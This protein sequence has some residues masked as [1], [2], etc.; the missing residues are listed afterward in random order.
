M[1]DQV[2]GFS[3]DTVIGYTK[4][5]EENREGSNQGGAGDGDTPVSESDGRRVPTGA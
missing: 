5:S 3:E 2:P 1:C 4:R